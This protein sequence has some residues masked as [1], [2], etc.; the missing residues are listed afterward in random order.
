M[1]TTR[2]PIGSAAGSGAERSSAMKSIA[3]RTPARCSPGMRE[4]MGTRQADGEIDRV[5]GRA[6]CV[7]PG[8]AVEPP[9]E[10]ERDPA[11]REQPVD[12]GLGEVAGH[13]VRGQAIFVE[14]AAARPG[15][16]DHR[17]MAEPG[18]AESA[19]QAGRAGADDGDA[20][21]ARRGAREERA[22]RPIHHRVD[23][24]AL[25][26]ADLDRLALLRHAHAD[27]LAQ[28]FGRT[29]AGAGAAERIGL[30]DG[31]RRTAQVVFGDAADEARHVD[32]GRAGFDARRVVAI[33]AALGLDQGL[34]AREARRGVGERGGV[35]GGI[36]PPGADVGAAVGR[37]GSGLCH[38]ARSFLGSG[39]S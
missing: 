38:A 34:R 4:R 5:V 37:Q 17:F 9:A 21:A 31:A 33:E 18:Q 16:V 39:Q 12:L 36:A 14:S 7:E 8:D 22:H 10:L 30:E 15:I 6:Q 1:T 29:D 35:A 3:S 27:L 26:P 23:G 13:L 32:A 20:L 19:R 2:R 24:I 28:L 11:D 25:Q